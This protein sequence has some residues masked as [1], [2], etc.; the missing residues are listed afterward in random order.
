MRF[1]GGWEQGSSGYFPTSPFS[2]RAL[3]LHC[4]HGLSFYRRIYRYSRSCRRTHPDSVSRRYRTRNYRMGRSRNEIAQRRQSA[5]FRKTYHQR[6]RLTFPRRHQHHG[7]PQTH[8]HGSRPRFHRHPHASDGAHH[9]GQTA[10]EP[11]LRL[12][13][14]HARTRPPQRQTFSFPIRALPRSRP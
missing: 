12:E 7:F 1:L 2:P 11:A 5:P 14:R 13:P 8:G 10:D 9:E 4:A 6:R 3:T